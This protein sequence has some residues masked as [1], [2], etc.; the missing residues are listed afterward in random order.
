MP[1]NIITESVIMR[2]FPISVDTKD[3][4]VLVLG[5]G[6]LATSKIKLLLD[7]DFKIYCISDDFTPEIL[8]Y[9]EDNPEKLLLK[10]R[11]LNEDF[12]FFG[13]DYC[14]IA[15]NDSKLNQALA[16]RAKR[17]QIEYFR[18]DNIGESSF[19]MNE[20]VE[21]G[22]LTVSILSGGLSST[23]QNQIKT[24][25]K[26]VLFKYDIEKLALLNDIKSTL[27]LKNSP[28]IEEEIEKLS[29][30]NVAVIKEYKETLERTSPDL[31]NEFISDVDEKSEEDEIEKEDTSS[32]DDLKDDEDKNED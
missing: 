19:K 18:A 3:K 10:G 15:T 5:G 12:V 30:Q 4:T 20:L 8:Q 27:V 16:E 24:D 31:V 26:N 25:I 1:L 22:G 6:R 28:N 21:E 7:T 32:E 29:K 23:V 17:S 13:Y 14:V 11:I 9:R 2:Y